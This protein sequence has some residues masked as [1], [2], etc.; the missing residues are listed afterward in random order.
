MPRSSQRRAPFTS[1][2]T[3]GTSSSATSIAALST[4]APRRDQLARQQ[5]GRRAAPAG[6]GTASASA[7]R[8]STGRRAAVAPVDRRRALAGE[9]AATATAPIAISAST[10]SSSTRSISRHQTRSWRLRLRGNCAGAR[11]RARRAAGY[12]GA[13]RSCGGL[14]GE[15]GGLAPRPRRSARRR[16]CGSCRRAPRSRGTG[17]SWRRPGENSTTSPG[18]AAAIAA[19]DRLAQH[20]AALDRHHAARASRRSAGP[21]SPIV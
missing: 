18:C 13:R 5:R 15:R 10:S 6:R 19:L 2:P 21:A 14:R 16:A 3:S 1:L 8:R 9:A 11:R 17:R 4:I 12:R 7:A 20:L